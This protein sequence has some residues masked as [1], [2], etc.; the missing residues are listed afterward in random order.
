MHNFRAEKGHQILIGT[1]N[2]DPMVES[3][4]NVFFRRMN[5]PHHFNNDLWG[6]IYNTVEVIC[7][8]N[9]LQDIQIS[10]LFSISYQNMRD[11]KFAVNLIFNNLAI[12]PYY[13][14]N[15]PA[16]SSKTK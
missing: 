7:Y 11:T 1:Y 14:S 6:G 2:I 4:K 15:T 9:I 13:L 10:V 12:S 8:D 5:S 3:F 16:Y